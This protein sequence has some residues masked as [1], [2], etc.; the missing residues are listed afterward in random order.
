M[1]RYL[2]QHME[3]TE[4]EDI[5]DAAI[6]VDAERKAVAADIARKTGRHLERSLRHQEVRPHTK[7][8]STRLTP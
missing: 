5:K 6:A 2:H 4:D 1:A 7:A 3:D 8:K